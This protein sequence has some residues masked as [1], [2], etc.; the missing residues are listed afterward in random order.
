MAAMTQTQQQSS[1]AEAARGRRPRRL[2]VVASHGRAKT[3]KV[4]IDRLVRHPKYGKYRKFSSY[5]HVHDEAGEARTG[6]V[7]EIAACRPLSRT[8]SWRLVKVVRRPG[9]SAG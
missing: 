2:A 1:T 9:P 3:I 5:L 7:V 6:D 8:K 4:R